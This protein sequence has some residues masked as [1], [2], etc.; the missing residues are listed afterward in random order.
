MPCLY[1]RLWSLPS[2]E[3]PF[4]IDTVFRHLVPDAY[5][6]GLHSYGGIGGISIDV[7]FVDPLS[8]SSFEKRKKSMSRGQ[9]GAG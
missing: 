2:G 7:S 8:S 1:F 5:K 3:S 6:A 9:L 4:D